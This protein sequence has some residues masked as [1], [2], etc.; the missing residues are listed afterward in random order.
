MARGGAAAAGERCDSVRVE[1]AKTA[2]KPTHSKTSIA[3]FHTH[4]PQG[5]AWVEV[6]NW[7]S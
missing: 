1:H 7:L 5:K 4:L 2:F 3:R 6:H